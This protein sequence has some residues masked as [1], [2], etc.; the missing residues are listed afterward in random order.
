MKH[1]LQQSFEGNNHLKLCT[2]STL[3]LWMNAVAGQNWQ[4]ATFGS[5]ESHK[6]TTRRWGGGFASWCRFWE[7]LVRLIFFMQLLF[8]K[9]E[10]EWFGMIPNTT[11]ANALLPKSVVI[12]GWV[13]WSC[14][15]GRSL[16]RYQQS[17]LIW[18]DVCVFSQFAWEFD[19]DQQAW[20]MY[21]YIYIFTYMYIYMMIIDFEL[22]T[23]GDISSW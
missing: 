11:S 6:S 9:N 10:S 19:Y 23:K 4:M 15:A 18:F 22:I 17:S 8:D 13:W 5:A 20:H 16:Q 12:G 21:I 1:I 7:V 3:H 2:I 14:W